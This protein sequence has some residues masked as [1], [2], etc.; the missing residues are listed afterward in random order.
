MLGGRVLGL[1]SGLA[2]GLVSSHP[3]APTTP[4]GPAPPQGAWG[5]QS[6]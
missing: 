3:P 2:G 4:R 5:A 1:T 6:D